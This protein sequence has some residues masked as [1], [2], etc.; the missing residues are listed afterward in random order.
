[1]SA[2]PAKSTRAPAGVP[3]SRCRAHPTSSREPF[4]Y[5]TRPSGDGWCTCVRAALA[6][7]TRTESLETRVVALTTAVALRKEFRVSPPAPGGT[8]FTGITDARAPAGGGPDAP[9]DPPRGAVAWVSIAPS[10]EEEDFAELGEPFSD[11]L[12]R[13]GQRSRLAW[14]IRSRGDLGQ[15]T[16]SGGGS[17]ASWS[18]DFLRGMS[19]TVRTQDLK[20]APDQNV[21]LEQSSIS[22]RSHGPSRLE[23]TWWRLGST[24][25]VPLVPCDPRREKRSRRTPNRGPREGNG[26]LLHDRVAVSLRRVV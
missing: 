11:Q 19:L 20:Q 5:G 9:P 18:P 14:A 22:K 25:R 2:K 6:L 1:M 13:G 12:A 21:R 26:S 7:V 23:S 3:S 15:S 10:V 24:P 8:T 16:L 17:G 4:G